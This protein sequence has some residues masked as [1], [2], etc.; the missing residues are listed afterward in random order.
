MEVEK[1]TSW[2]KSAVPLVLTIGFIFLGSVAVLSQETGAPVKELEGLVKVAVGKYVYLPDAKGLDVVVA[3]RVEG[4][5]E[6]LVGKEIRVKGTVPADKPTL[7]VAESIELK[8]GITY[9]SIYSRSA[10][11]D[12]RDYMD[13]HLRDGYVGLAITSI[14]KPEEWE[15]KAKVKIYGKL[16]KS[17]VKERGTETGV[18]HII[19]ADKKGKEIARVIVDGMTDYARF[20]LSKLRLFDKFWFYLNVKDQ[21]DRRVR[22]KTKELFHAD[23]VLCGLY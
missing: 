21:V 3:G 22:A 20:Y 18:T 11:P 12:L 5:V 9:S 2:K 10:E 13:Q 14:N 6:K 4:G 15:G 23:V 1:M 17:M 7:V 19:V 16:Q 8:E